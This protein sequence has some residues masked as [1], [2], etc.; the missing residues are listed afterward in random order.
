MDA[1]RLLPTVLPTPHS[2]GDLLPAFPA[3]LSAGAVRGAPLTADVN[4]VLVYLG[5]LPSPSSRRTM[6][7][8]LTALATMIC[9][10]PTDPIGF[11]WELLRYQHTARLHALLTERMM[12][13]AD[14]AR[15]PAAVTT[16]LRAATANKHLAGL[17]GVLR[18]AWRLGLMTAEDYHRA[19]DL[20]GFRVAALPAGRRIEADEIIALVAVCRRD[21]RPHG[22]RDAAILGLALSA[23]LRAQELV[24]LSAADVDV[25]TKRVV[26]RAGKGGKDRITYLEDGAARAVTAWLAVRGDVPGP[27]I[28]PVSHDRVQLRRMTTQAVYARFRR[29]ADEA[30]LTRPISP[31]D[32][33]RTWV[34][35]LLAAGADV[36]IVARMAGHENPAVTKKYDRRTEDDMRHAAQ[37]L[38]FPWH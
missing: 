33:R 20:R 13:R 5:R 28:C 37:L 6:R 24:D 30:Q 31:H 18:E 12:T 11:P 22:A 23:G 10:Q 19:V 16:P 38:H 26:V 3:G 7:Q 27:L 9:G 8:V 35:D 29:R 32:G 36:V 2:G 25:A 14:V 34:S 21:E 4:P 15:S 17:R 1:E